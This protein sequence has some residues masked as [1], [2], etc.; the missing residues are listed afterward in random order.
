[1]KV[2]FFVQAMLLVGLWLT[3]TGMTATASPLTFNE[4][5]ALLKLGET[6]GPTVAILLSMYWMR[7]SY[8]RRVEESQRYADA[9]LTLKKEHREEIQRLQER[10]MAEAARYSNGLEVMLG[11]QFGK[12]VPPH[13]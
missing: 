7:D 12:E 8:Q 6:G 5:D 1:M 13:E 4:T 2:R 9:L 3:A 11:R 10:S